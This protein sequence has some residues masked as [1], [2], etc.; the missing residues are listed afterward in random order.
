MTE[1]SHRLAL[2]LTDA[3]TREL[4]GA[5][6]LVQSTWLPVVQ[7]VA[8]THHCG[9]TRLERAQHRVQLGAHETCLDRC[10]GSGCGVVG[11]EVTERGIVV[12]AYGLIKADEVTRVVE[13]FA[14]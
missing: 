12:G 6:D 10:F 9:F 13:Q 5:T 4:E 8:H 3:L 1:L 2:D 11:N 14:D 7:A